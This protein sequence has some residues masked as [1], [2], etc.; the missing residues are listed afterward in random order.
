MH[1]YSRTQNNVDMIEN[2]YIRHPSEVFTKWTVS[3]VEKYDYGNVFLKIAYISPELSVYGVSA[4]RC[5]SYIP[6]F[7]Q[8]I[9]YTVTKFRE[10]T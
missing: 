8:L 1:R 9:L 2:N 4:R 7:R 10:R 5:W 3:R 6:M